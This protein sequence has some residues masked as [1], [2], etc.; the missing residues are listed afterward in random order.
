M[1]KYHASILIVQFLV[2]GCVVLP[3]D[4]G[5]VCAAPSRNTCAP[6]AICTPTKGSYLC[7]CPAGYVGDG[8]SCEDIDECADPELNTCNGSAVCANTPGS[9]E[10][11]CPSGYFYDGVTCEDIDE[12]ANPALHRCDPVASCTNT[13]GSHEC[14]CPAGFV[15]DGSTCEDI[16][17]C[18]DP[19][20][21]TCAELAVCTNTPGSHICSC[22][23]TDLHG[24]GHTCEFI[25]PPCNVSYAM[26]FSSTWELIVPNDC[27]TIQ[28]ALE[29]VART[30]VQRLGTISVEAGTYREN[31]DFHG[32][33]VTLRSVDGPEAT[34]LDGSGGKTSVVRFVSGETRHAVLEGFTITGGSGTWAG[35]GYLGG[36]IVVEQSS[37]TLR[38]LIIEGNTVGAIGGNG[39]GIGMKHSSARLD[40]VRII[41]NSSAYYG[42]GMYIGSS[43]N[44]EVYNT[45]IAD[46]RS[47]Y[48]GGI[49]L[50]HS[51]SRFEN[52]LILNN[53]AT[54]GAGIMVQSSAPRIIQSTLHGNKGDA[55][56]VLT[57]GK[58]TIGNTII[59]GSTG[60]GIRVDD[61]SVTV[62]YSNLWDNEAGPARG[63]GVPSPADGNLAV[64]PQYTSLSSFDWWG[65]DLTLRESSPLLGA[66]DPTVHN[67]DGSPSDI[68]AYGGRR[69]QDW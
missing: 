1:N 30:D 34:V 54:F 39:G 40:R 13:Q 52:A 44:T 68:G 32:V 56:R 12:C 43:P 2:A 28:A 61:G 14:E 37:P 69:G 22:P 64:D 66:G 23:G 29:A 21:N 38:N 26:Q 65:W 67:P 8:Q 5:D 59:S 62:R 6:V 53:E 3:P 36:G 58:P 45:I 46:N 16:D 50:Y 48:G 41:K 15:G 63:A 42:G 18:A 47:T 49:A 51:D 24:D 17:E 31:L 10:C 55:I 19:D 11:T 7:E 35:D 9:H 60:Y 4:D 57:E 33:S 27:T 20:L 25:N